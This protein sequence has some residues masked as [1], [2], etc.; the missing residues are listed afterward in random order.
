MYQPPRGR[1]REPRRVALPAN[2]RRP[3]GPVLLSVGHLSIRTLTDFETR[4]CK[5]L[6]RKD[7]EPDLQPVRRGINH[8]CDRGNVTPDARDGPARSRLTELRQSIAGV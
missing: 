8:P 2:A 4:V 1:T 3:A 6:A 7:R 5:L